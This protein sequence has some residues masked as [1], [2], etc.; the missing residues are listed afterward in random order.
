[1]SRWKRP[2]TRSATTSSDDPADS[3]TPAT[4]S[5]FLTIGETT[6]IDPEGSYP[7]DHRAD[8]SA[9]LVIN[10]T[11]HDIIIVTERNSHHSPAPPG[12][13]AA[14]PPAPA[15]TAGLVLA[16]GERTET[17]EGDSVRVG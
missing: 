17:R 14:Q 15:R 10:D 7:L 3:R 2:L 12:D 11:D 4:A 8:G 5:G 6:Y 13:L 1:M 9:T 16:P